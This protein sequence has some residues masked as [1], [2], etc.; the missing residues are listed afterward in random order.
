[1]SNKFIPPQFDKTGFHCPHCSTYAHQYW[2]FLR[3]ANVA[4]R[5]SFAKANICAHCGKIS[6]WMTEDKKMVYPK[7][8]TLLPPHR[9]MPSDC[10]I[11]FQEAREV[12]GTSPR[13]AAAL[14][15]LCLQR[16]MPY[17]GE[18]GKNINDDVAS[19]VSKGLPYEIQQA[20]DICRVIGNNAVHP[21]ELN[22]DDSPEV[23]GHIFSLIN[24]IVEDRISRPKKLA[25]LYAQLPQASQDAISKRD[26][27]K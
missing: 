13:S 15:R 8:I 17:I 7:V 24:F 10:Q 4:S 9:D 16:M 25:D 5:D 2:H 27:Q 20:L 11:D 26:G 18:K 14:L 22:P 19:L 12:F 6:I 23:A 3:L 21:G 1:M